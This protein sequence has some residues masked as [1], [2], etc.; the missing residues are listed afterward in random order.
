MIDSQLT[1][2][3]EQLFADIAE[4]VCGYPHFFVEAGGWL[5]REY[6]DT[7]VF[8][9]RKARKLKEKIALEREVMGHVTST[10]GRLSSRFS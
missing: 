1:P 6:F 4:Y 8:A 2:D 10:P 5:D 9:R 7:Q 3:D